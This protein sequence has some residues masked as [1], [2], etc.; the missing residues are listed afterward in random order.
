MGSLNIITD[1]EELLADRS[2]AADMLIVQLEDYQDQED[3]IVLGV[4]RGGVVL[5]D[6]IARGL[7]G[8][9]DIVLTRKIRAP[10]NPELAIGAV[11]EDGKLYL[12]QPIVTSLGLSEEY[13]EHEKNNQLNEITSRRD[14]YRKFLAKRPLNGRVVILTD[15]GIATGATM[16]AAIWA[17]IAE[18]PKKIVLAL[19]V[20]PPDALKR[21]A[22]DVE[23]TVCLCAPSNF[24]A[25]SQF[26]T[27]FE[28]V[29]DEQIVELLKNYSKVKTHE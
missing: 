21:L 18:F 1:H 28:Q 3:L 24:Q 16:Q 6:K 27:H 13:I 15:D 23:E 19:P 26:Y 8:E 4:P 22:Q 9:L 7:H 12:N 14:R 25:I 11:S 29:A 2:Q 10:S 17:C 5:A 20:A